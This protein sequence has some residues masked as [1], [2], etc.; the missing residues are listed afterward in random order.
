[1]AADA[2]PSHPRIKTITHSDL[3][4]I[5]IQINDSTIPSLKDIVLCI[6][7]SGSMGNQALRKDEKGAVIDDGFSTLDLV[8]HAAITMIM[9]LNDGDRVGITVFSSGSRVVRPLAIISDAS[10]ADMIG[11]IKSLNQNGDT[12]LWAGIETSLDLFRTDASKRKATKCVCLLTDGMPSRD[13][14]SFN[15]AGTL[16]RYVD[17]N[18]MHDIVFHTVG[19]GYSLDSL[20]LKE[21]S[22]ELNGNY[23]FISD[24]GMIGTAFTHIGANIA[25]T[26]GIDMKMSITYKDVAEL[27]MTLDNPHTSIDTCYK[28][29]RTSP[30]TLTISLGNVL[31]GQNRTIVIPTPLKG[32]DDIDVMYTNS[33]TT[34]VDRFRTGSIGAFVDSTDAEDIGKVKAQL[35]RQVI[36]SMIRKTFPLMTCHS[37]KKVKEM[38]ANTL[39][40]LDRIGYHTGSECAEIVKDLSG[41]IAEALSTR[42]AY[43]KWGKHYL[44]SLARAHIIQQ[45]NNFRDFG[46]QGF[47]GP[48]YKSIRDKLDGI[49]NSLPSITPSRS[50]YSYGSSFGYGSSMPSAPVSMASY[51]NQSGGCFRGD[52]IVHMSNGMFK[53]LDQIRG[54]DKVM[55]YTGPRPAGTTDCADSS[56]EVLALIQTKCKDGYASFIQY[57]ADLYIT[58]THPIIFKGEWRRPID[59][60]GESTVFTQP[61]EYVYNLVL[62]SGHIVTINGIQ[63]VT[64]AHGFTG[65]EHIEHPFF[66]TRKYVEALI[67]SD[68]VDHTKNGVIYIDDDNFVRDPETSWVIGLKV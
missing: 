14:N 51:N 53:P 49:F 11:A 29:L 39:A 54:G 42:D 58:P 43:D 30:N 24:A 22:E 61:C 4:A 17:I 9:G 41:Q 62:K 21:L 33:Q 10:R 5:D 34:D 35:F 32:L 18:N 26:Y 6:D 52:M 63:C 64:L 20:L 65:N 60:Q 40:F 56:Y 1:V 67:Y 57:D 50:A 66:G 15:Y 48:L 23:T 2:A 13:R 25:V 38:L 8:K 59:I 44:P 37:D 47:G 7:E 3:T 19:F 36:V 28:W 68:L 55:G 31:Y 16:K 46:I 27:Q 45:C 12:N